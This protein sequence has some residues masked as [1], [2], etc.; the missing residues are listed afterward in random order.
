M[1]GATGPVRDIVLL[2]AAAALLA[3]SG[4]DASRPVGDQLAEHL[5]TAGEAIDSG[6]ASTLLADW[7]DATQS[8]GA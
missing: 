3:Y 2:N 6:R 8:A 4:P 7:A 1:A 5:A